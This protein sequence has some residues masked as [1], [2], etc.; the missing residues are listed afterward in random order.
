MILVTGATGMLGCRLCRELIGAG[1]EVRG[2]VRLTSDPAVVEELNRLG[3]ETVVGDLRDYVGLKFVTHG[4]STVISTATALGSSNVA[5]TIDAVDRRGHVNL[6]DAARINGVSRF[7]Y[8]SLH[9]SHHLVFPLLLAKQATERYLI[10]SGMSHIII[11][12][13]NFMERWLA[14]SMGFDYRTCHA[15]VLGSGDA[16]L[17]WISVE[18][19]AAV[20]CAVLRFHQCDNATLTLGGPAALSMKEVISIFEETGGRSFAVETV[21]VSE[22]RM[23]FEEARDPFNQSVAALELLTALGMD[24][25]TDPLVTR[26]P[27]TPTSVERYARRVLA[28]HP[29]PV[30]A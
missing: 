28:E 9:S 22:L 27:Y 8:L 5:D 4:V 13:L 14:P 17:R 24:T 18:D 2:L 6:I 3:V 12:P 26:L 11:R 23:R 16:P 1:E 30:F 20:I 10:C 29:I 19:V 7:V 21:P 15:F 25:A